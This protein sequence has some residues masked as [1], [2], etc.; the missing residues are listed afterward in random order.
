M[1]TP[2]GRQVAGRITV[3]DEPQYRDLVDELWLVFR[4]G[5][6]S[7]GLLK[8]NEAYNILRCVESVSTQ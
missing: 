6:Q 1:Q 3:E 2:R 8:V 7:C 4:T 5:M